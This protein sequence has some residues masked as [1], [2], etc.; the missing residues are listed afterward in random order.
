MNVQQAEL[1]QR[2]QAFSLDDPDIGLPF[3][4]RL[5][6]DNGWSTKY[7]QRVIEE[8][9]KFAFLAVAAGHPVTPSDQVDQVWHLH[10]VYTRSYWGEFC[11]NVLQT[12]LHHGP[13]RGGRSEHDKFNDW[14][15]KTLASYEHFF[16]QVPPVDIWPP[17]HIRFDRDLHFVRV[18]TQQNWVLPKLAVELPKP[19]LNRSPIAAGLFLLALIVTGCESLSLTSVSNPLDFKGPEFLSFYLS[20]ASAAIVLAFIGRWYLRKP[21]LQS[22]DESSSLD[23]Y[24]IAYL[25]GGK[26][27]A[28]DAAIASLVQRGHLQPLTRTLDLRTALPSNSHPLERAIAQSIGTSGRPDKIRKAVTSATNS[29]EDRLQN[30]G[31]LVNSSQAKLVQW[32][33]ALPVFAVLLLGIAKIIVGIS[34]QKPVGFLV[35]LCII[36]AIVG[37]VLL[38]KPHRSRYGDRTLNKLLANYSALKNPSTAD[39]DQ[40]G[41]AF[42]LFGSVVLANSS[43]P[44]LKR[45]LV[46]PE[47]TGS[48]SGGD[49]GFFGYF[50]GGG[51][52]G[53]SGC[54]GG[55]CGGGGCGGCGGG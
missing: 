25:A 24:E 49:S 7:T 50:S 31:L 44:N 6:R 30:L 32:L 2:I 20:V 23:A 19:S 35:V 11:P 46:Q 38:T 27:R 18:N 1:Y 40:L 8:Y 26:D 54:G 14:Y 28:V 42:G 29:I 9:K 4:K 34:R 21:A 53:S 55:G 52:G 45:L 13:T 36:T 51:D 12:P 5:A 47:S 43:F 3:S 16:G 33:P 41:L 15:T 48:R 10:L 17:A 22:P 39:T 37:F